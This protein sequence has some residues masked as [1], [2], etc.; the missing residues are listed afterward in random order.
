MLP[1]LFRT[2]KSGSDIPAKSPFDKGGL[3][4][5]PEHLCRSISGRN[6]NGCKREANKE[7]GLRVESGLFYLKC[8]PV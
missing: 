8:P 7:T 4:Y 3:F 6:K 1:D 5:I 2:T